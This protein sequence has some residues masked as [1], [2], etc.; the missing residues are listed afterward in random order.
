L[1]THGVLPAGSTLPTTMELAATHGVS[2]STV[3][4]ALAVLKGWGL[5][6]GVGRN[7][8]E[9]RNA[10]GMTDGLSGSSASV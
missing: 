6:E 4:R 3:K 1:I 2:V 5:V 10:S 7:R 8:L 9:V